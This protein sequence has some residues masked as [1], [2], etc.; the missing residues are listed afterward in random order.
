MH[1]KLK[2]PEKTTKTLSK[3][4]KFL[5]LETDFSFTFANDYKI[6]EVARFDYVIRP[7]VILPKSFESTYC[8]CAK[9]YFPYFLNGKWAMLT[10]PLKST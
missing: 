1:Y 3:A 8:V 7:K 2:V 9:L 10:A 4:Q 5:S 6:W